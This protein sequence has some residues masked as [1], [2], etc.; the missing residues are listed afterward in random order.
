VSERTSIRKAEDVAKFYATLVQI[1]YTKYGC[2]KA[3]ALDLTKAAIHSGM[4]ND[5]TNG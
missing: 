2:T 1:L 4:F 5:N 3:D